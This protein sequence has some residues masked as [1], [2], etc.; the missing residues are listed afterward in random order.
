MQHILH[1]LKQNDLIPL[2][3]IQQQAKEACVEV[4][5]SQD[6]TS[7]VL[8]FAT[9]FELAGDAKKTDYPTLSYKELVEKIFRADT[10]VT[11]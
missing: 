11:W 3:I 2:S 8:D 9:V 10:V 7:I 1:I 4:V 5:L 6:A